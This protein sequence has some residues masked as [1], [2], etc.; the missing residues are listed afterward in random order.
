MER[1][2]TGL[3]TLFAIGFFLLVSYLFISRGHNLSNP[4]LS[5]SVKA[6]VVFK[7]DSNVVGELTLDQYSGASPVHITGTISGLD[8]YATR[9]L[10]IHTFGD[11]SDGCAS[12]GSHYNPFGKTH[13]GP[14]DEERHVGDLG[15]V[16]ADKK[17][18]AQVDISDEMISLSGPYSVVGRAFVVHTGEDDLGRGGH[19]DSKTT[20]HAGG[21]A[22]CGVI[23]LTS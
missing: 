6:T 2:G 7:G 11:L 16:V 18:I 4:H 10:H 13:G 3:A 1:S 19:D 5:N 15:N 8:P 12:T 14:T 17:G 9:G 21:R 22:A 20:G 23:G